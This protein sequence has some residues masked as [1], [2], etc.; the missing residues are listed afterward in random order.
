M[1]NQDVV[2]LDDSVWDINNS[3]KS[4]FPVVDGWESSVIPVEMVVSGGWVDSESVVGLAFFGIWGCAQSD[5]SFWER[6]VS[7]ERSIQIPVLSPE[8]A[9]AMIVVYFNVAGGLNTGVK[10]VVARK[11]EPQF[12]VILDWG[13]A[14]LWA[15]SL[16]DV[17]GWSGTLGSEFGNKWFGMDEIVAVDAVGL[18]GEVG[19]W[20]YPDWDGFGAWGWL[21][22]GC[23]KIFIV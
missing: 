5:W 12:N 4:E 23:H 13:L 21:S 22:W 20:L 16:L 8:F 9:Q 6:L 3:Q 18:L 1:S 2:L 7:P 19:P 17:K 10:G 14:V 11:V 15:H